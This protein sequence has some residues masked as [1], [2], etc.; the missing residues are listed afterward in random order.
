MNE[1]TIADEMFEAT[2]RVEKLI[3]V[4]GAM[5]DL[6]NPPVDFV[7]DFFESLP[8][9]AEQQLHAQLPA[10]AAFSSADCEATWEQVADAIAE[11][12]G[13]LVQAATP[14][15][16]VRG[17]VSDFS[18]GHYYTAWLYAANQGDIAPVCIAWANGRHQHDR[19]RG[20]RG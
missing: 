2:V 7:E 1:R 6:E 5:A 17:E 10:L 20:Q 13:F 18:W 14:V 8:T 9:G 3:Y 19:V 11:E 12:T 16:H 4:P 15:F